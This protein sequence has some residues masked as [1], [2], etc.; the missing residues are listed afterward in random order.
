[1]TKIRELRKARGMTIK[2]MAERF[3]V[4]VAAVGFWE[5]GKNEPNYDTLLKMSD[6]F[7]VTVDY[8]LGRER[9]P[10]LRAVVQ[11][12]VYARVTA[13]VPIEALT[14]IVDYEEIPE[15]MAR[16]GRHIAF[17][18]SGHSMEPYMRD[19][20]VLIV[21]VQPD[22]EDG[23][24]AVVTI[25]GD[26]GVVKKIKKSPSGVTL[27]SLNPAYEPLFYSNEEIADL[28]V[29]VVGRVVECRAKY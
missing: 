6:F 1:M 12:P 18:V 23:E 8:I 16:N 28:P 13:G 24:I 7:G 27:V 11:I 21:R 9:T 20:N 15:R 22:V 17:L 14:E 3:H 26:D 25:N 29:R 5:Q 10:E 4:S 2:D 19:G